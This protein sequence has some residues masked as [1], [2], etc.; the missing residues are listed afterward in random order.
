MSRYM[1]V[2]VHQTHIN[3]LRLASYDNPGRIVRRCSAFDAQIT[4][5]VDLMVFD[6]QK[7]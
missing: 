3:R 6:E 4:S 2:V 7:G 1:Q 5:A